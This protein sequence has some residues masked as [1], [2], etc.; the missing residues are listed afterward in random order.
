M[1]LVEE[2]GLL[3]YV[4]GEEVKIVVDSLEVQNGIGIIE[5]YKNKAITAF[6]WLSMVSFSLY[7][8][9]LILPMLAGPD[10]YLPP[11]AGWI[12]EGWVH[13]IEVKTRRWKMKPVQLITIRCIGTGWGQTVQDGALE[14]RL[15]QVP[16][17]GLLYDVLSTVQQTH[18]C[19]SYLCRTS[20]R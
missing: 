17:R 15:H 1:L 10:T 4:T 8:T 16:L 11:T 18:H 2:S 13:W 5:T 7:L 20:A 14:G 19:W 6:F 3:Y 9:H 12:S